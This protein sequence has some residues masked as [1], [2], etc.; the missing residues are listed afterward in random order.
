MVFI[1]LTLAD[2]KERCSAVCR[3]GGNKHSIKF[4]IFGGENHLVWNH[5]KKKLEA[6][7]LSEE[8]PLQVAASMPCLVAA[9][10]V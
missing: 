6:S 1:E 4:L 7:S 5:K 3:Q 10:S 8:G 2:N 9:T